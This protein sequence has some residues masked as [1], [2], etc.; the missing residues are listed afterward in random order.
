MLVLVVT[1]ASTEFAKDE[2]RICKHFSTLT[3]CKRLNIVIITI[4]ICV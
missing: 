2:E 4:I 1:R 3:E